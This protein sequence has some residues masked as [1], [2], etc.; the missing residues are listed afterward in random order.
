[1]D[2]FGTE[3]IEF[4]PVETKTAT[5]NMLEYLNN[6]PHVKASLVDETGSHSALADVVVD[7]QIPFE[8]VPNNS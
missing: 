2:K 3:R 8:A 1:M 4:K 6:I 5:L 7:P